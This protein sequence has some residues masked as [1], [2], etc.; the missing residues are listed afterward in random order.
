MTK[1][2]ISIEA[3]GGLR[4][5]ADH[6]AAPGA[7]CVILLHGGGQTRHAWGPTAERL[8]TAGYDVHSLDLRGHGD[9]A[10]S[11]TLDY[12]L[13][14]FGKDVAI[15]L[16]RLG[17]PTILVGASLGGIAALL[18]VGELHA[19]FVAGLVLVDI[20]PASSAQGAAAIQAFMR[21]APDG[22]ANLEAAADAV[23][24][25]L[26]HRPRPKNPSGLMKNLRERQ[27]RLH[28]HWDPQ[29]M[30]V[31]ASDQ[32]ADPNRLERAARNVEAP[33]L[34][35]RGEMSEL[36]RPEHAERLLEL[37]PH[38]HVVEIGGAHHMIA[39][40]RNSQFGA[41]VESFV[42]KVAPVMQG[43]QPFAARRA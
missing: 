39:G 35:I 25:Y 41:A 26:P 13:A 11:P 21:S 15:L 43:G 18:A 28:W 2:T 1:R 14:D 42:I 22:F 23:A 36:V 16:G 8:A 19:P 37:V 32:Q 12:R 34:L 7:A 27:G 6:W 10:W 29:F 31:C 4:L 24:A 30:A 9:S 3:S 5:A 33:T 38:A 17:R 40:D 20:A